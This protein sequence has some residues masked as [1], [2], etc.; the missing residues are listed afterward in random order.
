MNSTD[1]AS[2][3]QATFSVLGVL[4]IPLLSVSSAALVAGPVSSADPVGIAQALLATLVGSF[5]GLSVLRLARAA[6]WFIQAVALS[7]TQWAK[8]ESSA[9]V[10]ASGLTIVIAP[11]VIPSPS[12]HLDAVSRRGPPLDL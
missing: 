10:A 7:A 8:A 3:R 5:V 9:V 4:A 11:A 6:T 2:Q 12:H 1:R